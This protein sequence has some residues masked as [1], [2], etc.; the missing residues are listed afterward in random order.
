M[1]HGHSHFNT[2]NFQNVGHGDMC[3][4]TH[5]HIYIYY[6]EHLYELFK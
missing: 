3:T 1:K 4:H 5:T 2:Y 6:I